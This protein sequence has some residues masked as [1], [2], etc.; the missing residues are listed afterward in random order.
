MKRPCV[1]VFVFTAL[2]PSYAQYISPGIRL[3][4]DFKSG[5]NLGLKLSYGFDLD[6]N[7]LSFTFGRKFGIGKESVYQTHNYIDVQVGKL[8]NTM[9]ERKIQLFYGGGLGILFYKK[10]G[11]QVFYP[12][13]TVFTGYL[14]FTTF[15]LNLNEW[16]RVD[17]DIGLQLVLPFPVGKKPA[18]GTGG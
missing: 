9:G 6:N 17:P 14:L 4:Y 8:S 3:G 16:K 13:L 7:T 12:R 11:K 2:I 15:D 10:D 5:F 18:F 1:I